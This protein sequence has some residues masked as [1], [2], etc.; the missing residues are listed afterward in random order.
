MDFSWDCIFL[1][2]LGRGVPIGASAGGGGRPPQP[3]P[4]TQEESGAFE[5]EEYVSEDEAGEGEGAAVSCVMR[6]AGHWIPN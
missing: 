2:L 3:P 6:R 1:G 5:G 4:P